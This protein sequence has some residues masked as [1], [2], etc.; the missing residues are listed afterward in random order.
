LSGC[1]LELGDWALD[2]ARDF[3]A[4]ECGGVDNE[5]SW[6]QLIRRH[7]VLQRRRGVSLRKSWREYG[8]RIEK[9]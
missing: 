2:L 6:E 9:A 4:A 5:A 8:V 3:D 7:A 1:Y